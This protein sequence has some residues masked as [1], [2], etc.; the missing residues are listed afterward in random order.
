[1]NYYS[2]KLTPTET[3][4]ATGNKKNVCRSGNIETLTIFDTKN[5]N[6]KYWYIQTTKICCVFLETKRLNPK[7]IKW[8]EKFACYDF[9]IKYIKNENN[10]GAN[11]L[12]K[13]PDYKNPNKLTKPML[14]KNSDLYTNN[15]WTSQWHNFSS[16]QR[17][18]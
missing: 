11:V 17:F 3:N 12:N 14:V 2:K 15:K 9:A 1:M 10:V 8:L 7:Q 5:K 4:Y 13:N 18:H 6:T 16:L